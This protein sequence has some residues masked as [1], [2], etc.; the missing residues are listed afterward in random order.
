MLST[1]IL[2]TMKFFFEAARELQEREYAHINRA[3]F[4]EN[5]KRAADEQNKDY[6]RT[7]SSKP[8]EKRRE[9]LPRLGF[10]MIFAEMLLRQ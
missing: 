10:R 7:L 2:R 9:D 6:Y 8:L 4:I 5:P 3:A 1:P